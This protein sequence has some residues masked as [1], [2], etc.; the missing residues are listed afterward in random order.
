M[1]AG[2]WLAAG[3]LPLLGLI[4]AATPS[5]GPAGAAVVANWPKFHHD[6]AGSGYNPHET[7]LS[8]SNVGKLTTKWSMT[9][10]AP[11]ESSAA[12]WIHSTGTAGQAATSP[13]VASGRVFV[14]SAG[15]DLYAFGLR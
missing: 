7:A 10:G 12:L 3:V 4:P 2:R 14:G 11:V 6:N 5:A 15:G 1:G 13:A 8:P 9:T